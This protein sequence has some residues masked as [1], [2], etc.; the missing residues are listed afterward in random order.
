[1]ERRHSLF[2]FWWSWTLTRCS[3]WDTGVLRGPPLWSVQGRAGAAPA[4]A[5]PPPPTLSPLRKLPIHTTRWWLDQSF[6]E[7]YPWW[8]FGSSQQQCPLTPQ[9]SLSM[10]QCSMLPPLHSTPRLAE[11][12][13]HTEWNINE[14]RGGHT[15]QNWTSIC[16]FSCLGVKYWKTLRNRKQT[17][18]RMF[19]S[20][21]L[22][23]AQCIRE[24]KLVLHKG[25]H[26]W[27]NCSNNKGETWL[28]L[29]CEP[30]QAEL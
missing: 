4:R 5:E 10:S 17:A 6:N 11:T 27:G 20:S 7:C 18:G 29:S 30:L 26:A 21:S 12:Q 13:Y 2:S 15:V 8:P 9:S 25:F 19:Q 28:H 23:K 24:L 16:A 1:M 14:R 3:E 22:M